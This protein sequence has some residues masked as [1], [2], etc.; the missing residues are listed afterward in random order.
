MKAMILAA[1]RGKR[2]KDISSNLPKALLDLNGMPLIVYRIKALV[3][4]GITDI[5]INVYNNL[6]IF[7]EI[8][9]DGKK[10]SCKITY[11][12]EQEILETAGGIIKALPLLGEEAFI[13]CSCDTITDYD[14]TRFKKHQFNQNTLAHLI[15]VD[16][17]SHHP[18]G[19][20]SLTDDRVG[21]DEEAP[22][23][24][25]GF[26]LLHPQLFKNL[27]PGYRRIGDAFKQAI[28][29]QLVSGEYFK[30][31]WINT[32]TPERLAHAQKLLEEL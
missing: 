27:D 17:P 8:L 26:A 24:Y 19:D 30:G 14:F 23:N 13:N 11:S 28:R 21:L 5:V 25:A 32:D 29:N 7:K 31:L 15:L 6:D 4:A 22:Y 9:G 3:D 10:Y 16:N 20:F 1:G 18:Q 2:M 12:F